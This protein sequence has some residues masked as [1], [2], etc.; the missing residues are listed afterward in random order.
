MEDGADFNDIRFRGFGGPPT[1][2]WFR[3]P[4][5]AHSNIIRGLFG[6]VT[7]VVIGYNAKIADISE[8][9]TNKHTLNLA[10]ALPEVRNIV[11][12]HIKVTRIAGTGSFSLYPNEGASTISLVT[13]LD[14][15]CI[16]KYGT[17]RLQYAQTVANDD[18]DIYCLGYEIE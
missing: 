2:S 11:A 5:I 18:W 4:T 14:R 13:G 15:R 7:P 9:D 8:T 16:I 6:Y 10:T 3:P 12:V 1:T 17:N